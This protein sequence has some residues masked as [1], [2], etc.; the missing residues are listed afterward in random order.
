MATFVATTASSGARL[1]DA[2]TA[3]RV[4]DRFFWDGDVRAVIRQD[5]Q[6]GLA[7][8][9]VYGYDWPGVWKL[10]DGIRWEDF[11][12]DYDVDTVDAFEDFLFAM[13][14]FL[15]EPLT[16]QAVGVENCRFPI[17][18]CEWHVLPGADSIDVT[19][20]RHS[21]P[22]ESSATPSASP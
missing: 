15:A 11:E 18:A 10:P 4:L 13:A 5:E 16:V 6:D 17:S 7:R 19:G 12:P 2:Q 1:S 20:F 21:H 14:P 3:Q 22:E 9:Y 8:L